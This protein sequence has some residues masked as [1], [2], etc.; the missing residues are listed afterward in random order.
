M[1]LLT[2]SAIIVSGFSPILGFQTISNTRSGALHFT[3]ISTFSPSPTWPLFAHNDGSG[4]DVFELSPTNRLSNIIEYKDDGRPVDF[5]KKAFDDMKDA[6]TETSVFKEKVYDFFVKKSLPK[7]KPI[8]MHSFISSMSAMSAILLLLPT[9]HPGI[10]EFGFPRLFSYDL[11]S[12]DLLWQSQMVAFL[13]MIGSIMG[14]FRLPKNSPNVRIA[15]F[16]V[17]ALA[18]TQLSLVTMS[19]LNGTDVYL[20]D[21]FSMQGRALISAV[22][23]ALLIGS[24]GSITEII[25]DTEQKGWETVPNCKYKHNIVKYRIRCFARKCLS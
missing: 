11:A 25:G 22:N 10:D 3:R 4:E 5:P 21:A 12:N 23:T 20:F 8:S 16:V 19:S 14:I 13:Q 6:A 18:I 24:F 7:K 17:S 1:R 2:S 15:G 9:F